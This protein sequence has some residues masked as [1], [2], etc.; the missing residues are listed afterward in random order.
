MK[1]YLLFFYERFYPRGGW[2]DL[3]GQFHTLEQAKEVAKAKSC[4]V[5]HDDYYQIVD[6]ATRTV[7]DTNDRN[8]P[9]PE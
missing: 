3:T 7:V 8:A 2:H 9:T 1:R 4:G 6:M 5:R